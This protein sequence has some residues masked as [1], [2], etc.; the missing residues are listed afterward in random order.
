[1][2]VAFHQRIQEALLD[3]RLQKALY[4]ATGRLMEKRK[5]GVTTD[6]L[7][8]Y[9]ELRT[10]ANRIKR[11]TLENLD[12]YL[13]TLT[14]N[15]EARGGHVQW[16][17]DAGEAQVFIGQ[18][19]RERG[20]KLVVKSKSM[21]SEEVDLNEALQQQG[22]EPVETDLGEFIIQLARQRPYHIVA[23]AMHK[24]RQQVAD[25]FEERLGVPREEEIEKQTMIA[26]AVLRKKFLEAGMGISGA[27][28]LIAESGAVVIVE[29]EGNARLTTSSPRIHVALAGI[30]KII[31]R[32]ADLAVFLQ[33][34]GRSA[35]GQPL[36]SYT[37]FLSGSRRPGE[38]DGPDEFHLVLLDN[39]RSR[40]LADREKR[41]TLYC[42]RCGACLNICP[43]YR[44]I[45][46]YSYP[47]AYSGP[48]GAIL[49]PQFLGLQHEPELPFASS[50]CGACAEVCPVKIEIPKILLELRSEVKKAEAREAGW[51][52]EPSNVE[53]IGF[54]LWAWLM[55]HPR[56]FE[57]AGAAAQILLPADR[58]GKWLRNL[59][60]PLQAWTR[61]RDFPPPAPRS[62]RQLWR[63]RRKAS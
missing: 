4:A 56:L 8:D 16:C 30:E 40:V 25:L 18:L 32:A 11:H 38:L 24:T 26:R 57:L 9:Q 23:P 44:R 46:G 37:S 62:F 54:G 17:R 58:D 51:N 42:I 3:E 59:P 20:V 60:G 39:G 19:A 29:N 31:P 6:Q 61:W 35:T 33:L 1:M 21:T 28:F 7:P 63:T 53:K 47:G 5:S 48:I 2:S 15:V 27:N 43:V 36:T 13:E 50:L 14:R 45:G 49:T 55:R 12:Y 10:H 34:L 52:L 22:V 41:Q